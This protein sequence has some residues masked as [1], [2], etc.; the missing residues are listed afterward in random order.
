MLRQWWS[1]RRTF[2]GVIETLAPLAETTHASG[3]M[4]V[5]AIAEGV[6]LGLV[7]PPVEAD[8]VAMEA[9]SFGLAPSYGGPFAGVIA[10]RDKFVRQMPGRLADKLP[11]RKAA[12][13]SC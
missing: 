8:V 7:R 10:S 2:F 1:N 6:S 4:L 3:G 5:V 13:D 12:G 11:T 9:Q